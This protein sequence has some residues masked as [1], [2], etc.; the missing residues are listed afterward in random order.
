MPFD[1]LTVT[2]DPVLTILR[3]ARDELSNPDHWCK[4]VFVNNNNEAMC[5]LG[6]L[7]VAAGLA[8]DSK[9]HARFWVKNRVCTLFGIFGPSPPQHPSHKSASEAVALV[10]DQ[11]PVQASNWCYGTSISR[12]AMYNNYC[13][14]T[15]ADI[16][17]LFDRAITARVA[18]LT[19]AATAPERSTY[20]AVRR[21]ADTGYPYDAVWFAT[22]YGGYVGEPDGQV[23][24]GERALVPA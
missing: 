22:A 10:A 19:D 14:T 18:Q 17:A 16:L 15:H 9:V 21:P 20:H 4:G 2:P 8:R 13:E 5:A 1:A 3:T 7:G 6:A 24:A 11:V 23:V 12:V